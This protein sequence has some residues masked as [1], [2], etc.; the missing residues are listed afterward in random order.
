ML[1]R[2]IKPEQDGRQ[3]IKDDVDSKAVSEAR[4]SDLTMNLTA[5]F[6]LLTKKKTDLEQKGGF[7][8]LEYSKWITR[9][10]PKIQ[11]TGTRVGGSTGKTSA[12]HTKSCK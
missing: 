6:K 9:S 4:D 10:Y 3:W 12:T 11:H 1:L 2:F 5:I 8:R 7:V